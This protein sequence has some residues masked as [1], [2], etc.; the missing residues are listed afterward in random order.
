M[1]SYFVKRK[2]GLMTIRKEFILEVI[3]TH[4]THDQIVEI[5]SPE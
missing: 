1:I 5:Y 2:N 3:E 4:H